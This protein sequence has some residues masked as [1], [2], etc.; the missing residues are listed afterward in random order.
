MGRKER[1][2][3]RLLAEGWT[4]NRRG[5][6]EP[7]PEPSMRL[8]DAEFSEQLHRRDPRWSADVYD[9]LALKAEIEPE[10]Y[11]YSMGYMAARQQGLGHE[12]AVRAGQVEAYGE[13]RNSGARGE[14][15]Y[16]R[17][18]TLLP[19]A[20]RLPGQELVL[21]PAGAPVAVA[22]VAQE[23]APSAP[24]TVIQPS[25]DMRGEKGRFLSVK[26]TPPAEAK[27]Q[28][29]AQILR[30]TGKSE[31]E[32]A[33]TVERLAPLDPPEIEVPGPV[34]TVQL[35]MPWSRPETGTPLEAD[36]PAAPGGARSEEE[37]MAAEARRLRQ[38]LAGGVGA[39]LATYGI[40]GLMEAGRS[41]R[42]G[43]D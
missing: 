7:P 31:E 37:V 41:E 2:E 10:A 12:D 26:G 16:N 4:R 14:T 25:L 38:I 15:A 11:H 34:D 42:S 29:L 3:A 19:V 39:L 43:Y 18:M 21:A 23:M 40:S 1:Q 30:S 5:N 17:R 35:E 27:R 32:V 6:L 13:E 28:F 20:T 24:V 9:D 33:S 8:G 22:P 36:P